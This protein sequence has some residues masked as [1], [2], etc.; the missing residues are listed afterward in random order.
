MLNNTMFTDNDDREKPKEKK[1]I[2]SHK[3]N[4]SI[5]FF[6]VVTSNAQA[7]SFEGTSDLLLML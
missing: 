6:T 3:Q 4:S 1:L 5:V 7:H 2:T